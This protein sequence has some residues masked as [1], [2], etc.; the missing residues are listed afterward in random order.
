LESAS[1]RPLNPFRS[2]LSDVQL[3]EVH[4]YI[5]WLFP[6]S[7]R[8]GAQRDAPVLTEEEIQ[9]IRADHRAA[10]TLEHAT[11]R[12]IRFYRNTSGWLSGQDYNHLR[13][14]PI[15]RSLKLLANLDAA[16]RF[17][18]TILDLHYAAGAPVNAHALRGGGQL[19]PAYGVALLPVGRS[20][21]MR[22]GAGLST[23]SGRGGIRSR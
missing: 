4:D 10:V 3:E 12:M 7:T 2:G 21:Y 6:L 11:E 23:P 5:Q 9:A 1:L 8:S 16:R 15:I 14:T 18:A 22:D 19:R 17:Y 20:G 13:I